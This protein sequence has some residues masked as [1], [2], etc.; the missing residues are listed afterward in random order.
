MLVALFAI[1]FL[2]FAQESSQTNETK[3][4]FAEDQY[5]MDNLKK[6]LTGDESQFIKLGYY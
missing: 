1:F 3:P 2:A 4:A 6:N 5:E